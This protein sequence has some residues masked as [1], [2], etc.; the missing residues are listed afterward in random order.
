MKP[1]E[2]KIGVDLGGT[3]IEAVVVD[4]ATQVLVTLRT[5]TP[6]GDYPATIDAIVT[7]VGEVAAQAGVD[8]RTTP[9]GIGTP[10]AW[11]AARQQMKNCNSTWLNGRP[12]LPDLIARL[13]DRVRIANDADCFVLAEAFLGAA[14]NARSVFG[15]ILGTGVG[16]G[17]VVD[18]RLLSGPNGLT[19]EWGHTPMPYL[20]A[21]PCMG[22]DLKHLEDKLYDRDCYCG[23][24]NCIE[25]FISGPGLAHTHDMLWGQV[26]DAQAICSAASDP[27]AAQHEHA[28]TTLDLYGH[29]LSR[30]L[31]QIVN[32]IDPE[33]LILGGGLSNAEILYRKLKLHLP[34]YVFAGECTTPVLA[35]L[36]GDSSGVLGAARL[37]AS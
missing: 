1:L 5:D 36:G 32:I 4:E 16:G 14:R 35:P 18:G 2:V 13:G 17:L 25:T 15:V 28:A 3:K 21:D 19:G 12:L 27:F 30:A 34:A 8:A 31:A 37:W 20:R 10:G 23:R 9:I 22:T 11:V 6:R 33:A 29:M 7:L 26:S 24:K